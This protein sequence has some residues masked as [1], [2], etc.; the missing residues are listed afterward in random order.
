MKVSP[1]PASPGRRVL[2]SLS[3]VGLFACGDANASND[4]LARAFIEVER[5]GPSSKSEGCSVPQSANGK[6]FLPVPADIHFWRML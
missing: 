2:Q 1:R 3:S 6:S 5:P 4:H